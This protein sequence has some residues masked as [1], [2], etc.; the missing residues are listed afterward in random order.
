M[1]VLEMKP[2]SLVFPRRALADG[3][4]QGG[5]RDRSVLGQFGS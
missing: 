5:G 2:V 1:T 4:C 3:V